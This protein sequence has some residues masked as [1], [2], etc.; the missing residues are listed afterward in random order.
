MHTTLN[1]FGSVAVMPI[2]NILEE[3]NSAM[4]AFSRGEAVEMSG[5]VLSAM[6][7]A[8]Y[9][10]INLAVVIT[11]LILLVRT[12]KQR[13][14]TLKSDAEIYI[15][16]QDAKRLIFSNAG[17]IIYLIATL[18]MFAMSILLG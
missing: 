17:T 11:G 8:S 16:R 2:V 18:A 7:V 14:F 12:F 13:L 1:F 9:S 15:P 5:F 4:E 3:Y 6:A 10:V